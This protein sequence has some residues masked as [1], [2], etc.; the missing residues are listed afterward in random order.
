MILLE[1]P[2]ILEPSKIRMDAAFDKP[3]NKIE[4]TNLIL[5]DRD[6]E[7]PVP[8]TSAAAY[9]S[10][11]SGTSA[12][13]SVIVKKPHA[14]HDD[15]DDD[16]DDDSGPEMQPTSPSKTTPTTLRTDVSCLEL[17]EDYDNI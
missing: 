4:Y 11:S 8:S 3:I 14:C 12:A 9:A 5:N 10:T 1:P 6:C 13:I 17:D 2:Q 15:D 16:L 7:S